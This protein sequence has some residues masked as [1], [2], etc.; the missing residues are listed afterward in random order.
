MKKFLSLKP[1]R[2]VS[3]VV[4]DHWIEVNFVL[5]QPITVVTTVDKVGRVNI[6]LK[7]WVMSSTK[8]QKMSGN[9]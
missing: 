5:P 9:K 4:R 6:A 2:G 7:S 1:P 3:E 8:L